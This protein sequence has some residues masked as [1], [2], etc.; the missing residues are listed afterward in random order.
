MRAD[1]VVIRTPGAA[2]TTATDALG[3]AGRK[4]PAA[5]PP[6]NHVLDR[7]GGQIAYTDEGTGPLVVM[8]P[9]LGDLKEEYRFLAPDLTAAGYRV[10]TIDLRGH[11]KTS[12][13]W[14]DYTSAAL[15]S[16]IVAL[17]EHLDAGTATVVGTSMGA[18]AAAWAAAET[19]RA[20]GQLVLI[21]PFVRDVPLPWWKKALLQTIVHAAFTG[22]WGPAAWGTYY[23]SLY[24][25]A[26]PADFAAYK[27]ALVAN[28]KEKG[29]M[30]ALRAMLAADKA[31]VEARLGA[32]RARTMVIM[33][34]KDPDF[35][36]PAAEAG[37]IA[38][39]L[40]GSVHLVEGA[41][42]YPHVEMPESTTPAVLRFLG[43]ESEARR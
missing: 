38:R 19:Q 1:P 42:H 8:V 14:P 9:G 36:D 23:G 40:G 11:G 25:T 26:K 12:V 32:V 13:N 17:V 24:P 34:T 4:S 31:D 33:G 7:P 41:G 6:A 16:D 27:A 15:G 22:P 28:L 3:P 18:G 21:G 2:P 5:A 37:T 43:A 29:R 10:A 35:S 30:S 39:L 20:I